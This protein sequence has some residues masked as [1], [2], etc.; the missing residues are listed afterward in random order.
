M[1][2]AAS[3]PCLFLSYDATVFFFF[4]HLVLSQPRIKQQCLCWFKTENCMRED[5]EPPWFFYMSAQ[6]CRVFAR[7]VVDTLPS[8]L[9]V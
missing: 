7:N 8:A 2:Q 5:T 6:A 4:F 1:R 9:N 3:M